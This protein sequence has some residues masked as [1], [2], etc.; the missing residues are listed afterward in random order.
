MFINESVRKIHQRQ[1]SYTQ[2]HFHNWQTTVS[3]KLGQIVK[4]Q[5]IKVFPKYDHLRKECHA[6][7]TIH[8]QTIF[9]QPFAHS[10]GY[11]LLIERWYKPGDLF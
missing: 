5:H 3:Y 8:C 2:N 7:N 11:T 4:L 6:D 1:M 9:I 10:M